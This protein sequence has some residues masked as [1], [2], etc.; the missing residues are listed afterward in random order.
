M[1]SRAGVEGQGDRSW[2]CA[3]LYSYRACGSPAPAELNAKAYLVKDFPTAGAYLWGD[4]AMIFNRV[5]SGAF[6]R[7][8]T[9]IVFAWYATYGSVVPLTV[10]THKCVQVQHGL[11]RWLSNFSC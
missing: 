11:S 8:V 4:T 1:E 5:Q 7:V 3:S 2:W 10:L 6:K 9:L